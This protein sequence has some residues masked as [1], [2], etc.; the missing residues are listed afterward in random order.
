MK[1]LFDTNVILSALLAEGHS[2]EVI[3]DAMYRHEVYYTDYILSEAENTL[4][5]KFLVSLETRSQLLLAIRK[6]FL[7]GVAASFVEK[8]CRD[9][10]DDRIL[11]DSLATGIELLITGDKDLLILKKYKKI[12]IIQPKEYWSLDK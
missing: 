12:L 1:I 4:K 8:V 7:K 5:S 10:N 3:K 9:A 2:Y 6:N 11:A